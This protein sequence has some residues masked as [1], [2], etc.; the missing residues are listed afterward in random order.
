ME[1][2]LKSLEGI[3]SPYYGQITTGS[4][5]GDVVISDD[6]KF[7]PLEIVDSHVE[8]VK[9]ISMHV[10]K[11]QNPETGEQAYIR[12]MAADMG[13]GREIDIVD[14]ISMDAQLTETGIDT[15]KCAACL[16][17]LDGYDLLVQNGKA[18]HKYCM[19]DS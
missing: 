16:M 1:K 15:T 19:G 14:P 7:P 11:V 8:P 10:V 3:R 2:F 13:D 4:K 9:S 5:R 12:R 17:K 18:Y 6:E